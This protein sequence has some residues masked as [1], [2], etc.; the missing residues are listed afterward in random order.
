MELW[1]CSGSLGY[2]SFEELINPITINQSTYSLSV[3]SFSLLWICK[4]SIATVLLYFV[5]ADQR[6]QQNNYHNVSSSYCIVGIDGWA[7]VM[8]MLFVYSIDS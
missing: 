7:V 4:C 8:E 5:W 3:W 1:I 6:V 2:K